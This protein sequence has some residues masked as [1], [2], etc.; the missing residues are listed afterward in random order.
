MGGPRTFVAQAKAAGWGV[1]ADVPGRETVFAAV[2]QPWMPYVVF[3]TLPP[4]EFA[5][6]HEPG[7][8]R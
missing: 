7:T 6:F 3:R 2:T 1:L 8:R 4:D 5:A